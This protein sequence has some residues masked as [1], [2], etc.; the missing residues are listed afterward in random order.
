[1]GIY[2]QTYRKFEGKLQGRFQRII[3]IFKNEFIRRLKNKWILALLLLSW[4]VGIF[5]IITGGAFIAFFVLSFIWLLLFTSAVG[6]PIIAEDFQYNAITLYLSRPLERVDYFIGKYLTLFALTSLIALLPNIFISGYIIGILYGTSTESFDYYTFSYSLIAI[7]LL[8]TFVFT[9]IGMAFSA[10]TNNYK[11]AAGGIFTVLFFSNI[12]S[13]ALSNLY[14]DIIYCSIWGNF[15]II[16]SHLN[17]FTDNNQ[18]GYDGNISF[19]ILM[20]I[21]IICLLIVWLRIQRA[22]ISE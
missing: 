10:M 16:F 15:M 18:A 5:P 20:F 6:G 12:L 2:K 3:T 21:S 13:I 9:N 7:G 14:N 17:N 11:Y 22:E 19:G 8:M 4:I 1:M